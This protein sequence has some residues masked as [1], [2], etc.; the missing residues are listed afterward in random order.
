MWDKQL[1]MFLTG[2]VVRYVALSSTITKSQDTRVHVKT[3]K[4]KNDPQ[5]RVIGKTNILR[6][7]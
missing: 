4:T 5:Q 7:S 2:F 1:K 3:V 6:P